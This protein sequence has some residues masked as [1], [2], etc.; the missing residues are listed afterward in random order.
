MMMMLCLLAPDSG[1][2]SKGKQ[3]QWWLQLD[4]S[5]HQ[6]EA[7][8]L[9]GNILEAVMGWQDEVLEKQVLGKLWQ[10]EVQYFHLVLL[11]LTPSELKE[12]F[13]AAY[14]AIFDHAVPQESTIQH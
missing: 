11:P 5:H 6:H 3:E 12:S 7:E 4:H 1:M 10:E 8:L 13:Y 2:I 14:L 9:V